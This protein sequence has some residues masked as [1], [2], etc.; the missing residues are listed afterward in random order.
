MRRVR[1]TSLWIELISVRAQQ[2]VQT[3]GRTTT[4][5][6][7]GKQPLGYYTANRCNRAYV[8]TYVQIT[9]T[10]SSHMHL[11]F[12]PTSMN[13]CGVGTICKHY[14]TI[15]IIWSQVAI[16][17]V[18]YVTFPPFRV[19]FTLSVSDSLRVISW[20]CKSVRVSLDRGW[21]SMRMYLNEFDRY[22]I[23]YPF[24]CQMTLTFLVLQMT[25]YN[26]YELQFKSFCFCLFV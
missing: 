5:M 4:C 18:L 7:T 9:S 22:F 2:I 16:R 26:F 15:L 6:D 14:I 20:E 1:Q 17:L 11:T 8:H 23:L 19:C 25:S 13:S 3:Y 10:Y 24:T 21:E 12:T